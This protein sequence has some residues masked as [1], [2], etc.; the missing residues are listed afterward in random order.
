MF[1]ARSS[2]EVGL[3]LFG[4]RVGLFHL[5]HQISHKKLLHGLLDATLLASAGWGAPLLDIAVIQM[6]GR[7]ERLNVALGTSA[8]GKPQTARLEPS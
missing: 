5:S 7:M 1:A 3:F 8:L 2:W 6:Q 4:G